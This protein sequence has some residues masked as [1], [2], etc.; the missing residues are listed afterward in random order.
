MVCMQ[1]ICMHIYSNCAIGVFAMTKAK[2]TFSKINW[3]RAGVFA[4][5]FFFIFLGM[6]NPHLNHNHGPKHRPRAVI[7]KITK[8]SEEVAKKFVSEFQTNDPVSLPE[9]SIN[10]SLFWSPASQFLPQTALS[11]L[12]ARAPPIVS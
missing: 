5:S 9:P 12:I 6:R 1:T 2:T 11:H 10:A 3:L 4:A 7:E 8:T